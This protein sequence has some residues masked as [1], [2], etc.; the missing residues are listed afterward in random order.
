MKKIVA[1][2]TAD[3]LVNP[4]KKLHKEIIPESKM[5]N[6]VDDSLIQEVIENGKVTL[7]VKRRVLKYYEAAIYDIKADVIL[8]TCSSVGE[9]VDIANEFFDKPIIKIDEPMAVEAVKKAKKIGVLATLPTTLNPT[10]RL[11]KKQAVKINK[12][13]EIVNG[14]AKG[15]F[16]ALL[17]GNNDKHDRLIIETAKDIAEKVDVLVLAQGSMA[18]MKDTLTDIAGKPVLTS[19]ASGLQYVRKILN[20]I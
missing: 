7:G 3:A 4:L 2:Y 17:E 6:I 12:E 11:L 8:N 20:Y 1:I 9:L 5:I 13:C 10:I 14:L 18:R 16:H 15:A 19:P